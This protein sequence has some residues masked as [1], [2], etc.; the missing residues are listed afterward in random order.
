MFC[1]FLSR[2]KSARRPPSRDSTHPFVY[3]TTTRPPRW[4]FSLTRRKTSAAS[5]RYV[6]SEPRHRV[7]SESPEVSEKKNVALSTAISR[8]SRPLILIRQPF[9]CRAF[10]ILARRD[11]PRLDHRGCLSLSRSRAKK[12]KTPP[13]VQGVSL[14]SRCRALMNFSTPSPVRNPRERQQIGRV[15]EDNPREQETRRRRRAAPRF[16]EILR[17]FVASLVELSWPDVC[18]IFRANSRA[19]FHPE[20]AISK[21]RRRRQREA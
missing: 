19:E 6:T 1:F 9:A 15:R 8:F 7:P 21:R 10:F 11:C 16:M 13:G 17:D 20:T 14:A 4:R 5:I 3:F 2:R 12:R 18:L